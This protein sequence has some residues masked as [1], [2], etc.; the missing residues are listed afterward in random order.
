MI[1]GQRHPVIARQVCRLLTVQA[2]EKI[3]GKALAHVADGRHL[4]PAIGPQRGN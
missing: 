2:A 4:R 3:E 1:D